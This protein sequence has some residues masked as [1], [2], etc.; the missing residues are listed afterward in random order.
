MLMVKF[1]NYTLGLRSDHSQDTLSAGAVKRVCSV[2]HLQ[3]S[4]LHA[5]DAAVSVEEVQVF[6]WRLWCQGNG[7]NMQ[8][9]LQVNTTCTRHHNAQCDLH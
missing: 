5:L 3:V 7:N 9:T 6:L 1:H 8:I 2:C 4:L